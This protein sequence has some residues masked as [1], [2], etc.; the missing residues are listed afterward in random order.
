MGKQLTSKQVTD[1]IEGKLMRHF[2][3]EP[4]SATPQQ[5]Y[6]ATSMVVKD[7]LSEMWMETKDICES[8]QDKEVFYLSMEFLPG[9]SLRNNL[10]ILPIL[11]SA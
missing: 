8:H 5:F 6:K 4:G 3:K 9:Q 11:R 10:S 1:W 7:I 2:G